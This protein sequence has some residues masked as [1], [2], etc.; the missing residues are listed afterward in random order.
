MVIPFQRTRF[1][2][3]SHTQHINIA[4]T[5]GLRFLFALGTLMCPFKFFFFF[6]T[7]F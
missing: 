1:C 6:L 7:A 3:D 4:I 5:L 2:L